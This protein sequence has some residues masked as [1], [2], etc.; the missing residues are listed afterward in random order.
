MLR[1]GRTGAAALGKAAEV[2]PGDPREAITALERAVE[3][4]L[5][6]AE[7]HFVLGLAYAEVDLDEE[8]IAT[9]SDGL[10]LQRDAESARA[11]LERVRRRA[12]EPRH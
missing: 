7:A 9:L 12:A 1:I 2:R 6:L 11:L 5:S 10:E 3:L 8:A 4:E